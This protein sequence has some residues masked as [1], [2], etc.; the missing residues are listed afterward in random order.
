MSE[1]Q[2]IGGSEKMSYQPS[3]SSLHG[4]S[5]V[6]NEGTFNGTFSFL[7]NV[8]NHGIL[9]I[10]PWKLLRKVCVYFYA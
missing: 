9:L 6:I 2:L 7:F 8:C 1:Y 5:L 3:F 10:S 4:G